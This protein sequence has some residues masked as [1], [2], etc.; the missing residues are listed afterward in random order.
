MLGLLEAHLDALWDTETV[1]DA[2]CIEMGVSKPETA[3]RHV[4]TMVRMGYLEIAEWSTLS[5]SAKYRLGD[6]G[7]ELLE[8][9]K[10]AK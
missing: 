4:A 5:D 8:A 3:K 10:E 1:W 7:R 9:A 2:L 6:K